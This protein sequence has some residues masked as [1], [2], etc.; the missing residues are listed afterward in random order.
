MGITVQWNERAGSLSIHPVRERLEHHRETS[1][2]RGW[3]RHHRCNGH[4][5]IVFTAGVPRGS[6]LVLTAGTTTL[7]VMLARSVPAT[8]VTVTAT[9]T[10]FTIL[11]SG[12]RPVPEM[13]HR[14]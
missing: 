4:A 8:T 1:R 7:T 2:R 13:P 5:V 10:G 14:R 11:A 12:D 3:N 9:T 6:T